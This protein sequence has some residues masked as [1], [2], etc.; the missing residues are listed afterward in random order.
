MTARSSGSI[1]IDRADSSTHGGKKLASFAIF[2]LP[3]L[4][5]CALATLGALALA[6]WLDSSAPWLLVPLA[7]VIGLHRSPEHYGWTLRVIPPTALVHLGIGALA[8]ALYV[9]A[10]AFFGTLDFDPPENLAFALARMF[11]A[12]AL[13]EEFFFRGYLQ[14]SLNRVFGKPWRLAGAPFGIGLVIQALAFALCHVAAG[15]WM[16][17]RVFFFGVFAG[18]L[19]ERSG[20]VLSPALYHAVANICYLTFER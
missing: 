13:P 10:H 11:L 16:K 9:S 6:L 17:M 18:W 1:C 7:L 4:L 8:L 14:S 20:G 15:D 12:V 5:E 2:H 3:I 19:R